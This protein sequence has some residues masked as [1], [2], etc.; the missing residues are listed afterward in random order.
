M[1]IKA[2][3]ALCSAIVNKPFKDIKLD[4]LQQVLL[5]HV[6]KTIQLSGNS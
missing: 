1:V 5:T 3:F 2:S 4:D 6:K